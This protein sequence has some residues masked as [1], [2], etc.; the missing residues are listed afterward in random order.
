MTKF[1]QF[2]LKNEMLVANGLANFVGVFF[3]NAIL[4]VAEGFP[5]DKQMW[6]QPIPYWVDALFTPFAFSFVAIM[7]MLYEKPIRRYLNLSFKKT[8]I[9]QNLEATARQRLLNEPFV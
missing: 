5:A 7:T 1:K 6:Q 2:H 4:Y 8:S 3:V 9:P